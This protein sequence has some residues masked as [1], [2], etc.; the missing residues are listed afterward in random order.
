MP[1]PKEED[2]RIPEAD[3]D[4]KPVVWTMEDA[5]EGKC[6]FDQVGCTRFYEKDRKVDFGMTD[7][8]R[9]L[10]KYRGF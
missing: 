7:R 9:T 10:G 4:G 8:N 3:F 5:L 2:F 1:P 6:N